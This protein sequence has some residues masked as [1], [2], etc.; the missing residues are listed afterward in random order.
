M[1]GSASRKIGRCGRTPVS[2]PGPFYTCRSR[3][4]GRLYT[5]ALRFPDTSTLTQSLRLHPP[6]EPNRSTRATV[7][8]REYSLFRSVLRVSSFFSTLVSPSP[9]SLHFHDETTETSTPSLGGRFL[10][11][12][13]TF[14]LFGLLD[15]RGS[16]RTPWSG[17]LLNYNRVVPGKESP[18]E[19]NSV[20][21]L[22]G[23]D[24]GRP[25]SRGL[26]SQVGG[27]VRD[28]RRVWTESGWKWSRR[29]LQT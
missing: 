9:L 1:A 7:V 26:A 17:R 6:I 4:V 15:E 27:S 5:G 21:L 2:L 29:R 19:S 23:T 13:E 14:N 11:P 12:V 16:R 3:G 10:T 28:G 20:V 22:C 25:G 18:H 24:V 8:S